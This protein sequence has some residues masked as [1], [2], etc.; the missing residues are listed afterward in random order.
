MRNIRAHTKK[1]EVPLKYLGRCY[2]GKGL[3]PLC[4]LK[5][6]PIICVYADPDY[7]VFRSAIKIASTDVMKQYPGVYV[8]D[9]GRRMCES[10]YPH[11]I[12]APSYAEHQSWEHI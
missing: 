1:S 11:L 2:F 7:E 9:C 3:F 10:V 12:C 6:K 8:F 4:G 5:R